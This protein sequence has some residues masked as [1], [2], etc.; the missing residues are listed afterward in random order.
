MRPGLRTRGVNHVLFKS[1]PPHL[2]RAAYVDALFWA[3][4]ASPLITITRAAC[5]RRLPHH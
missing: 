4:Q 1:Q 5:Q 3:E 2:I